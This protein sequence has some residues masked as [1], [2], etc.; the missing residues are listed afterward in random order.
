M[1]LKLILIFVSSLIV[2][3]FVFLLGTKNN[4]LNSF[5]VERT[6]NSE[7]IYASD[8]YDIEKSKD[9][10]TQNESS[11]ILEPE[12]QNDPT[13]INQ[14]NSDGKTEKSAESNTNVKKNNKG[15]VNVKETTTPND[16][17]KVSKPNNQS[18]EVTKNEVTQ[19]DENLKNDSTNSNVSNNSQEK[20][21]VST[22]FY[23]SITGGKKEFSSES[24]AFAR[25][26]EIKSKEL[27]YVLDYNETHPENPIKP[28]IRYFRVYPSVIDENGKYW[29]YLH[30]FCDSGEGNDSKLKSKF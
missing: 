15:N 25:G 23:E 13:K 9:I 1:K 4:K 19:K 8:G 21:V 12:H 10:T 14:S 18:T 7:Q 29:Y 11:V 3:S 6:D 17:K 27:D 24:E 26:Q 28:D 20:S 2:F 22:K 5:Y 16:D 30:F